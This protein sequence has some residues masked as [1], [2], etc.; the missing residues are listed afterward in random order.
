M[1]LRSPFSTLSSAK[2]IIFVIMVKG[3]KTIISNY[4]SKTAKFNTDTLLIN[5][6]NRIKNGYL[7]IQIENC[8]LL[9]SQGLTEKYKEAKGSLPGVTYSGTFEGSHRAENL[10]N[11]SKLMI[12]DFDGLDPSQIL[13][14]KTQIFNDKH[15]LAVWFSP[16]NQG[17]KV[18]VKTDSTIETHKIYF[19]KICNYFTENFNL[20]A[21]KSGS[22]ICRICFTSY[23]PEILIKED[24]IA[25]SVDLSKIE[26]QLNLIKSTD[27]PS[28]VVTDFKLD[29]TLFYAT[30]GRNSKRDRDTIYK[31][32]KF[33]RH[34]KLSITNS[35][36]DWY[37]IGLAIANTFT[38]EL[39]KKYYLYLC[40]LDGINHDE[41]KSI[42]LLDYCYRNRKIKEVNFSTIIYLA[43]Q[44]GFQNKFKLARTVSE[45]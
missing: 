11:Y 28:S 3:E 10:T 14:Q 25:F 24:C 17:L 5:E 12:I 36:Q 18:L 16:S 20:H 43:E 7:K 9:L 21:D 2:C 30:E 39:G 26:I 32:I 8:R 45:D 44:K 4:S 42:N 35:Y 37:R 15:V 41:Y 34:R 33:L 6:L 23:D 13:K 27:R 31:I 19:G 38:Y 22:D 1:T 40:E 29:K